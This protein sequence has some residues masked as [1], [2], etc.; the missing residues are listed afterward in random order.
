M[1]EMVLVATDGGPGST[2]A[3][4]WVVERGLHADLNVQLVTVEETDW[5]PLGA[6]EPAYRRK[7]VDELRAG[8]NRVAGQ[9]GISVLDTMLLRGETDEA[10]ASAS[11]F[12]D[13]LVVASRHVGPMRAALHN[14]IALQLARHVHCTLIAVPL[15]WRPGTGHVVVGVDADGSSDAAV[16]FGA[17][18]A[19]RCGLAL[20]LLHTWSLPKP[21]AVTG[22]VRPGRFPHLET[23]HGEYL[24]RAVS[25]ARAIAPVLTITTTLEAGDTGE[26]LVRAA[27]SASMVVV[28]THRRGVVRSF[29]LGSI[30]QRVIA[31]AKC[32]TAVVRPDVVHPSPAAELA[33][34]IA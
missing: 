23:V 31:A 10:L 16:D 2:A 4:N 32:A 34:S 13:L 21:F 17:R 3:L 6:D 28:G 22:A 8:E 29:A 27:Q 20:E 11:R 9:P 5:L 33:S 25:R 18:E 7:Y 19:Q 26:T 15:E 30:S 14:S 1:A 12:A 24:D